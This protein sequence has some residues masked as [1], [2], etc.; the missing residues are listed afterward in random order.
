M[1]KLAKVLALVL[2]A[3]IVAALSVLLLGAAYIEGGCRGQGGSLAAAAPYTSIWDAPADLRPEPNTWLTYPEWHIVYSAEGFAEV[4]RTSRPSQFS[5]VRDVVGF[6]TSYCAVN[7]ATAGMPG[8]GEYKATIYTIGVSYTLELGAKAAYEWTLGRVIEWVGG[9]ESGSDRYSAEVQAD[10][11]RFLHDTPWYRYDFG[12]ALSGLWA[13]EA[14]DHP[15][16]H[17]ER[18]LVLSAEYA[19]KAVYAKVIGAAVAASGFDELTLQFVAEGTADAVTAID[20]RLVVRQDL[21]GGRLLV[22][23]PRYEE[24]TDLVRALARSNVV[25]LEIAGNDDIF[26]TAVVP[27]GRVVGADVSERLFALEVDGRPGFER[28][29]LTLKVRNLL[30]LVRQLEADGG[31]L[32]HVYDY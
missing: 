12:G 18:R 9:A 24:F 22:D 30:P 8:R 31:A 25:V 28:V 6:W 11:G 10:Y 19:T 21:G 29:G 17:W 16:R 14:G 3:P 13:V 32:E 7:G 15:L 4:L 23:A 5:Y 20:A 1:K 2:A 26:V 27:E